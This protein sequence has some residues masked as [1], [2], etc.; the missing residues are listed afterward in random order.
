MSS[1]KKRKLNTEAPSN[2]QKEKTSKKHA[3]QKPGPGPASISP[4]PPRSQSP[5]EEVVEEEPEEA[6]EEVAKSF[7][8]LVGFELRSLRNSS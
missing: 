1:V 6:E 5:E 4:N 7:K 2:L 3:V 8:D